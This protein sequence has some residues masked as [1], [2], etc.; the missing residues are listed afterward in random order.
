MADLMGHDSVDLVIIQD[1]KQAFGDQDVA[2]L[3][4]QSH[5]PGSKHLAFKDWPL[6]NIVVLQLSLFADGLDP[7]TLR[8]TRQRPTAPEEPDQGRGDNNQ[9][10]QKK[11]KENDLSFR[12]S[13]QTLWGRK[14]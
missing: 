14:W 1:L 3:L 13:Q 11:G 12:C 9:G 8:A 5:D 7:C 10:G 6:Q 2:K 4:N